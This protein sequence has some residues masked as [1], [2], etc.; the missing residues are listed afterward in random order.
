MHKLTEHIF[1]I[2]LAH[3]RAANFIWIIWVCF[4]IQIILSLVG[5]N[6]VQWG[7]SPHTVRGLIGIVTMPFLHANFEHIIMNSI[8]LLMVLLPLYMA[9]KDEAH[10]PEVIMK[11][12][13]LSGILVWVFGRQNATHIGASA[14]VYGL[15]TYILAAGITYRHPLLIFCSI[16]T[17]FWMGGS[18]FEGM[19][20]NAVGPN[21]SWEGHLCGAA[22]GL[23]L[24]SWK[25]D[26]KK[27]FPHPHSN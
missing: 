24:G 25:W 17:F 11:I 23:F 2:F 14:L 27:D 9:F 21:V 13:L 15:T 6:L 5:V 19:M 10:V 22:A 20:P 16:A 1:H 4:F 3:I 18:F 7:V 26:S 8:G 12:T